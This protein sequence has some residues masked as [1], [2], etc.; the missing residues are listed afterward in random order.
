MVRTILSILIL[1]LAAFPATGVQAGPAAD[2]SQNAYHAELFTALV[3][4]QTRADGFVI[5]EHRDTQKFIQFATAS[6][7]RI[8][9]DIPFQSLSAAENIRAGNFFKDRG[10]DEA[11]FAAD[12]VDPA[13]GETVYI[14]RSYEVLLDNPESAVELSAAFFREVYDY[15]DGFPFVITQ[16]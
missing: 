2:V 16:E 4:M 5:I 15:A 9:L 14:Q 8:L 10:L 1:S 11:Q 7:E 3:Q 6:G 12:M 13:T